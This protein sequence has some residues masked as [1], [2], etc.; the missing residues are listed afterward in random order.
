M[1]TARFCGAMVAI[2]LLAA[3]CGDDS[4][5]TNPNE[6]P[7][8]VGEGEKALNLI[9]WAGY[10]E[11]GSTLPDYDWVH[12]FQDKTG[13]IV[14][15][16]IA[17]TS[18]EMFQL[19]GTGQYDGVS[20]SG[21]SSVRLI[22][23]G[24]VSPVN[25]SLIKNYADI[26]SFLKDQPYNTSGGK[27][28]GIPHG[29]GANYLMWNTDVVKSAPDSW[30]V[31]FD[32]SSPYKGKV[33]AYD[34]PIYI[35]DA[36]L[37]LKT[38]QPDL[39]IKDPYSLT[40]KQFDAAV[41]LLKGQHSIIGEYWNDYTKTQSAFEQGSTVIGTTW[42][43]IK[44]LATTNGAHLETVVP[45]EGSTGWS[46]TWMVSSKAAHP[47]CMYMW[48]DYI[49]SPDVQAQVAYYFGEAPANP[50]ACPEIATKYQDTTHC[51]VFKATDEAFAKSISFWATPRK[52]CL[53][54]SGNDCVPFVDWIKAW[55]EIKG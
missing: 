14:K 6:A 49:T 1:K 45:K 44:N 13:C 54:G 38:A 30:S 21:D 15:S 47:N 32:K 27:N 4:P 46:D 16:K 40:Q 52:K 29:W 22:D 39:G 41:A 23:A 51:D 25:T 9:V 42:Q 50:K 43:V 34:A 24:L 53:D 11:D 35:A 10:A 7:R 5:S 33:T 31:V 26:S 48:M 18:D 17:A 36:A 2:T 20:A 12:P 3:A 19:M 28:Y 55:T 8:V 37:Y